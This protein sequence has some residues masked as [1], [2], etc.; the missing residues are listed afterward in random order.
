[1]QDVGDLAFLNE[2]D[3]ED[4]QPL[5]QKMKPIHFVKLTILS[6]PP[7]QIQ[8]SSI[9]NNDLARPRLH[10]TPSHTAEFAPR[11]SLKLQRQCVFVQ[12]LNPESLSNTVSHHYPRIT[13]FQG[14][15]GKKS[16]IWVLSLPLPSCLHIRNRLV[17]SMPKRLR[18]AL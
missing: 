11:A 9:Q 4:L 1:V 13:Y 6:K 2:L 16:G 3:E 15:R 14:A 12:G 18:E 17:F 5:K 7:P 8:T 10:G